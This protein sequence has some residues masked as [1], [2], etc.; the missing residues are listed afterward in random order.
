MA[1]EQAPAAVERTTG[2]DG[3]KIVDWEYYDLLGVAGNADD[4]TLKKAY[5]KLAIK[6][7]P[8]KNQGN[9]EAEVKFKQIGEA[10]QVLSD[11]KSVLSWCVLR[12]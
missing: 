2:P 5:R 3:E 11:P 8:D 1:S 4:A 10:Y 12:S 7:H 6:Y 9:E